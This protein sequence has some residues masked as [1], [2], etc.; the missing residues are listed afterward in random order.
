VTDLLTVIE[1]VAP[2]FPKEF[3][4][5]RLFERKYKENVEQLVFPFL[6]KKKD[7]LEDPGFLIILVSWL[8]RYEDVLGKIGVKENDYVN[9]RSKA[10]QFLPELMDHLEKFMNESMLNIIKEDRSLYSKDEIEKMK[11]QG[12][13][14]SSNFS[15]D[16]F[17]L[18]NRQLEIVGTKTRGE[19]YMEIIRV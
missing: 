14:I 4:I 13:E 11:D 19:V 18:I 10:K 5:V 9:L 17:T 3:E 8:D 7:L 1:N 12:Q 6:E 16:I 15:Q 2:C